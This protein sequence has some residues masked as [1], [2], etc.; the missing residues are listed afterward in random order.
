MA[1]GSTNTVNITHKMMQDIL[2]AVSDYRSK[3]NALAEQLDATVNGLIPGSFSGSA[4]DG[5]KIFYTQNIVPANGEGLKD[6]LDAV[7]GMA[8]GIL[9]SIPGGNGLD[10]QLGDGNKQ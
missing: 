7:E 8:N 6:L 2:S 1:M 4:A 3:A 9:E 10:D 5:F